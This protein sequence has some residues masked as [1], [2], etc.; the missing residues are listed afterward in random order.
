MALFGPGVQLVVKAKPS[1]AHKSGSCK[2]VVPVVGRAESA[3]P[4]RTVM[5]WQWRAQ[6]GG[7]APPRGLDARA[8]LYHAA[9]NTCL[10]GDGP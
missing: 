1:S 10:I 8:K 5:L 2:A 9:R 6:G 7:F 4:K 3:F